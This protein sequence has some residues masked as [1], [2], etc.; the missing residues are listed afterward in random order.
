MP[1]NVTSKE[2]AKKGSIEEFR[3]LDMQDAMALA[4]STS[5]A[6]D[7][8][9]PDPYGYG[10]ELEL[11]YDANVLGPV[12]KSKPDEDRYNKRLRSRMRKA[13]VT[14]LYMAGWG[15]PRIAKELNVTEV[16]IHND[17]KAVNGEWRK[18]AA[19]D[20]E[21]LAYRDLA[22]LDYVFS[23]VLPGVESDD[24]QTVIKAALACVEIIRQRG[25][26][27]GYKQGV[28]MDMEQYLREAAVTMGLDPDEAVIMGRRVNNALK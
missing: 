3:L 2:V 20:I 23:K 13:K 26:I 15:I 18:S 16:T 6:I 12:W 19:G 9:D 7:D 25:D 17:M 8:D 27:L 21:V 28:Q 14:E 1:E 10:Q 4:R 5:R 11:E 22:R 24:M